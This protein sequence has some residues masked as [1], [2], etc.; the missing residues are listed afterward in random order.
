MILTQDR[1]L[2]VNN[3]I[4]RYDFM[5]LKRDNVAKNQMGETL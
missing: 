5:K 2:F 4:V 1:L 3:Q